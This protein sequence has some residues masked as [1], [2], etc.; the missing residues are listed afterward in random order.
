MQETAKNENQYPFVKKVWITGGIF[1]L[2]AVLLLLFKAT[3]NVF[4][5]ILAGTLI[6]VYFRG[7][8]E[9][10][11]SNTPLKKNLSLVISVIGSILIIAGIFWLIGAKIQS[12]INQLTQTLP[13]MIDHA[14]QYLQGIPLVQEVIEKGGTGNQLSSFFANL[15]TTTFGIIADIYI[16][17]FIGIYFTAGPGLYKKGVIS[18]VPPA[19]RKKAEKVWSHLGRDLKKWLKGKLFAMLVVFV[20]TAIGLKIIGMPMWL[21]LALIAGLLNFVP[22]FGPLFAMIPAVLVALSIDPATAWIVAG[23]YLFIQLL[24]SN[25]ITPKVQQHLVKI[26]PALIIISQVLIGTLTGLWG[27]ILATPLMLILIILVRDLYVKEAE[28]NSSS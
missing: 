16:I 3:F 27:I 15:F 23:M 7:L 11:H 26:P 17:L 20:L 5:L 25:L 28:E 1:A 13:E 19:K 10:I 24:E 22:N 9:F 21:A 4:I 12:Q 2:I 6:A 8:S 14:K 18:L